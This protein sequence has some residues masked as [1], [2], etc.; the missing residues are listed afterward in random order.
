[1]IDCKSFSTPAQTTAVEHDTY[2]DPFYES[3]K[4]ST[5]MSMLM[6]LAR[7][8]CTNIAFSV[9]QCTFFIHLPHQSHT[10][11]DKCIIIYLKRT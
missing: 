8:S 11:S 4:Y 3:C 2:S 9:H 10:K 5:V 6:Y 7:I 1:M